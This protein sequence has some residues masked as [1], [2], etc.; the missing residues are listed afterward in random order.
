M[1]FIQ[2]ALKIGLKNLGSNLH[3]FANIEIHI[4][5]LTGRLL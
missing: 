4:P 1:N 2:Y 3:A 5:K